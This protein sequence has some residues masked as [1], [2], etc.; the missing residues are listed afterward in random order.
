MAKEPAHALAYGCCG[1]EL[2]PQSP[3]I[4]ATLKKLRETEDKIKPT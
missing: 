4:I 3:L 2:R 1:N